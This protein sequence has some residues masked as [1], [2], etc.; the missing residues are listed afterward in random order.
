[1]SITPK[2][3]SKKDSTNETPD[4]SLQ[5][6]TYFNTDDGRL[7]RVVD[8]VLIQEPGVERTVY[9][10]VKL[11]EVSTSWQEVSPGEERWYIVLQ[12]DD[13]EKRVGLRY[14][15]FKDDSG[16]FHRVKNAKPKVTYRG[17]RDAGD[18]LVKGGERDA[19][20]PFRRLTPQAPRLTAF[21]SERDVEAEGQR[22]LSSRSRPSSTDYSTG[23]ARL[24]A[25]HR[26]VEGVDWEVG[27]DGQRKPIIN[28]IEEAQL[29]SQPRRDSE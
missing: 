1:M 7:Y 26:D 24:G 5:H 8:F 22:A 21:D 9:P 2:F 25:G 3:W 10:D 12:D 11:G 20:G 28:P 13:E 27:P 14:R 17:T 6:E 29:K 19:S 18:D 16:S 15:D 4:A 23:S